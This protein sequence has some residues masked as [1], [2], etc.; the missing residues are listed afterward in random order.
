VEK[1]DLNHI[2][3][4]YGDFYARRLID[5]LGLSSKNGVVRVSMVQY[6]TL[7]EIENLIVLLDKIL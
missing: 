7:D 3:I 5:S 6:N 4:R 1:V 2:G